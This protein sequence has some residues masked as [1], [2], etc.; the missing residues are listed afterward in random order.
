MNATNVYEPALA[1]RVTGLSGSAI[2]QI[3][4]DSARPGVISLAGG[5]PGPEL[6][7]QEGIAEASTQAMSQHARASLQYGLTEG[8]NELREALGELM[9][10]RRYP[11]PADGL[12]VTTGAQQAIA[13]VGEALLNPGDT[14]VLERPTYTAAIDM[15]TLRQ[16][17][18]VTVGIDEDGL[19]VSELEQILGTVYPKLLYV[20]SAF[21]NPSGAT[22]PESR[23]LKL[24][25]LAVR[26]KFFILEDDPYGEL[27]FDEPSPLSLIALAERIPGAAARCIYCSSLSKIV[28]PGLRIG[29]LIAPAAI[30]RGAVVIKQ[31]QDAHTSTFMQRV[32]DGYLRS[33]R[34][35]AATR[36]K[37][38]AY[39]ERA[40]SLETALRR[41][42]PH[43]I[44]YDAPR[45]GMFVWSRL[46]EG[47]DAAALLPFALDEGMAFV[48]GA[49][50][51]AERPDRSTMRLS[52]STA[53]GPEIDAAIQ[54][55]SRAVARFH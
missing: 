45:G 20:V 50:F 34:L 7:D 53:S 21:G 9:T 6:F 14:V 23:R 16:T 48:P 44:A 2:R 54:R 30:L 41:Y 40:A 31:L 3:L 17:R 49:S 24:L 26:H 32:A 25:E 51:M 11:V 43:S 8:I 28:A 47:M 22:M 37:R 13:L 1:D 27:Y 12:I 33:G 15:A 52:F 18:I 10:R 39:R 35:E 46:S 5:L 19:K 36:R 55:L 4:R 38:A 42:M 29:W